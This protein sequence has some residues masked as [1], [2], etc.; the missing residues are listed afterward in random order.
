MPGFRTVAGRGLS[1]ALWSVVALLAGVA[2]VRFVEDQQRD[3]ATPGTVPRLTTTVP[4]DV[5]LDPNGRPYDVVLPA[6][7]RVQRKRLTMLYAPSARI[8]ITGGEY[9]GHLK[10]GDEDPVQLAERPDHAYPIEIVWLSHPNGIG[11]PSVAGILIRE[12]DTPVVRW[13]E[14]ERLAYGTDGGVGGITTPE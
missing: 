1:R 8:L 2:L 4:L 11:S 12:R 13:R 9:V 14:L 6:G 7:A 10:P 5:S 3:G